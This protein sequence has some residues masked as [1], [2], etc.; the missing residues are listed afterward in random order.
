LRGKLVLALVLVH[1]VVASAGAIAGAP[2]G[3]LRWYL[4][5]VLVRPVVV[6]LKA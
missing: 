3:C 2:C 5:L 6:S 1:P 4:F